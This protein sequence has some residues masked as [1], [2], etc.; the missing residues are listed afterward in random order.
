MF[1]YEIEHYVPPFLTK[2]P[3]LKALGMEEPDL[4]GNKRMQKENSKKL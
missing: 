2:R 1:K 3:I 4:K